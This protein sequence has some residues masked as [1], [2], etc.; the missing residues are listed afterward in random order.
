V[1]ELYA[2]GNFTK[3]S[4]HSSAFRKTFLSDSSLLS[5]S[6]NAGSSRNIR[7]TIG[8]RLTYQP[9][10]KNA[11]NYNFSYAPASATTGSRDTTSIQTQKLNAIYPLSTGLT[12]NSSTQNGNTFHHSLSY[13]HRFEKKRRTLLLAVDLSSGSQQQDAALYTS[14]QTK[15]LK[16]VDERSVNPVTNA[17][18][19]ARLLYSEPLSAELDM[20]LQYN[21]SGAENRAAK[22]SFSLDPLT[23]RYDL[24]DS[25]TSNHFTGH[26]ETHQA[27]LS[28][29][30]L[31]G[32]PCYYEF[33]AGLQSA[34]QENDNQDIGLRTR[35]IFYDFLPQADF[36]YRLSK[37]RSIR[38]DY[39][40]VSQNPSI[41][42][43]QPLPD[44]SDPY[45]VKL[46][47]PDL[48]QSFSQVF[49]ADYFAFGQENFR[50]LQL[51]LSG[52]VTSGQIS[53]AISTLPGGVQ[54]IQFVNL[55]GV[56]HLHAQGTY[57]FPL[58]SQEH[59]SGS[60][61][62]NLSYGQ[63]KG[64]VNAAENITRSGG[65][66]TELRINYRTGNTLFVESSAA[67]Q[68]LDNHYSLPQESGSRSW[69]QNYG[70]DISCTLPLMLT[71]GGHYHL[72][73]RNTSNLPDQ[74]SSLLNA[75]VAKDLSAD[76][77]AQLRLSGFNLLDTAAAISQTA[78]QNFIATSETNTPHRLVLLS[79]LYNFRK[80]KTGS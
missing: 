23:G 64:L 22:N 16:I 51:G 45:L 4:Q 71:A 38:L 20:K 35:R 46:G 76:H 56:Y 1:A 66:G 54:Q 14:V 19:N 15:S 43:L 6:A 29:S 73:L 8:G 48:R 77:A 37:N 67:L 79:F 55:D 40:G 27:R 30:N 28:L 65:G 36:R 21:W 39:S 18:Y 75:Y 69:Q 74:Q 41:E 78:G 13:T 17:G 53:G 47:N 58:I 52:D 7:G 32:N 68:Y 49:R 26:V 61:G 31:P 59:G 63:D 80:F 60:I 9:D 10:E 50:N 33:S 72:Q 24:P 34:T 12:N 3:S 5:N 44:L 70:L 11:L 25:L 42:Q 57:G 2:N 62:A